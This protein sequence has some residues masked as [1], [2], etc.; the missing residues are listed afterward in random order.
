MCAL[1]CDEG[2]SKSTGIVEEHPLMFYNAHKQT[3]KILYIRAKVCGENT[4]TVYTEY[5]YTE[6][7][8]HAPKVAGDV[9]S[10]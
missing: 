2:A 5:Y 3:I 10:K 6:R 1:L 4:R 8:S 9:R 7:E